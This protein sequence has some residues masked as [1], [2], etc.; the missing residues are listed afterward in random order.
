MNEQGQKRDF[1]KKI[2]SHSGFL[3]VEAENADDART[4]I[5]DINVDVVFY[6]SCHQGCINLEKELNE[7][8][9]F[10]NRAISV[11]QL[12]SF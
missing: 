2:V 12:D 6:D 3:V 11:V 8:P 7:D 5:D 9:D 4:I 1:Y 10:F